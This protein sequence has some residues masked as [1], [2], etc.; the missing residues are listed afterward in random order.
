MIAFQKMLITML[1]PTCYGSGNKAK[2]TADENLLIIYSTAVF[3]ALIRVCSYAS[4]I[5][6]ILTLFL[7]LYRVLVR[8]SF[9]FQLPVK[10]SFT[11]TGIYIFNGMF[12]L[13]VILAFW[14]ILFFSIVFMSII[15][16]FFTGPKGFFF[17]DIVTM[18]E[19][20]LVFCFSLLY[21]NILTPT[22]LLKRK[23]S[24]ITGMTAVM[25][26]YCIVTIVLGT[27]ISDGN[28]FSPNSLEH[29]LQHIPNGWQFVGACLLV[30]IILSIASIV[31]AEFVDWLE[32]K[33]GR[34]E[35]STLK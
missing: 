18:Q 6:F 12:N 17:I 13:F 16:F 24:R 28:L 29:Y 23:S 32:R 14:S 20:I 2:A 15:D 26:L 7:F 34:F 9:V 31:L 4:L 21:V 27:Q 8:H 33:R 35:K 11:I 5:G 3:L 10:R 1:F 19:Q 22:L 25:A 30:T